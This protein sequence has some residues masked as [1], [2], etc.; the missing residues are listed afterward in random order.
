MITLASLDTHVFR[1][2]NGMAGKNHLLD[3]VGVFCARWL[4]LMMFLVVVMRAVF[5]FTQRSSVDGSVLLSAG[6][7]GCIA[8]ALAFIVSV[9]ASPFL[10]RARPYVTLSNVM[11]LMGNPVTP[12][13]FPSS[14]SS[15]AFAL[16]F[17]VFAVD[18]GF[19]SFLLGTATLVGLGRIYVGVHYPTDIIGGALLGWS[20]A[21]L[22]G[23]AV[24]VGAIL[25]Y[26]RRI[27]GLRSI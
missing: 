12:H 15:I 21:L 10:F 6:M 24:F 4:I 22:V 17:S 11:K 1:A 8:A 25:Q 18:R 23:R 14:H 19:G 27:L 3:A 13:S 9:L 16:A 26:M 2:I 5:L 7:K 20:T